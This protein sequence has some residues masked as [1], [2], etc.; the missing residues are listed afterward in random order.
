MFFISLAYFI[1][2]N[3]ISHSPYIYVLV[4]VNFSS[5]FLNTCPWQAQSNFK[6]LSVLKEPCLAIYSSSLSSIAEKLPSVIDFVRLIE[7][8]SPYY[9]SQDQITALF[10]KISNVIIKRCR[11]CISLT[12]IFEGDVDASVAVVMDAISCCEAWKTEYDKRKAA[13]IVNSSKPWVVNHSS[14]F[15]Q[16]DAFIQRCKDLL[17]VCSGQKHFARKLHAD[18]IP[19]PNFA[20]T[21]GQEIARALSGVEARFEESLR[22]LRQH[23]GHILDVKSSKYQSYFNAFKVAIKELE[24]MVQNAIATAFQ[25]VTSIENGVELIEMFGPLAQRDIIKRALDKC[26]TRVFKMFA[27]QLEDVKTYFNNLRHNPPLLP[28]MPP[29]SGASIWAQGLLTQINTAHDILFNAKYIQPGA[30][31][32]EILSQYTHLA[33]ALR[34][35]ISKAHSNW[36]ANIKSDLCSLLNN[37]L[38][39]R[40]ES[41][42]LLLL[43]FDQHLLL[44]FA[45]VKYWI[46][47]GMEIPS[48]AMEMHHKSE[49]LR[50]LRCFTMLVVRDYN[51][52]I[53]KLSVEEQ[54]LFRERIRF[55]DSKVQHGLTKLTW[56]S[57]GIKDYYVADC[58]MHAK[59]LREHVDKYMQTN[60]RIARLCAFAEKECMININGKRTYTVTEFYEAQQAQISVIR[61]RYFD[62][63]REII[64]NLQKTYEV[65]KGDGP[66]V[67]QYWRRFVQ[68]IEHK[69]EEALRANL[70]RSLSEL[71]RVIVGDG[72]SI[73]SPVFKVNVTLD[74]NQVHLQPSYS[75]L[76]EMTLSLYKDML[77]VLVGIEQFVP[78]LCKGSHG[79]TQPRQPAESQSTRPSQSS[80][81]TSRQSYRF[82]GSIRTSTRS[83]QVNAMTT[84]MPRQKDDIASQYNRNFSFYEAASNDHEIRKLYQALEQG[85]KDN[86]PNLHAYLNIWHESYHEFWQTDIERFLQRY[87]QMNPPLAQFDGD[88]ARYAEVA[89]NVQKEETFSAI[90]FIQ[91][92]CSLLKY[93]LLELCHLWQTKLT[94]L[95][96]QRA[97]ADLERLRHYLQT[98]AE[99]LVQKPEGLDA[100]IKAVD[101]LNAA[102][103]EAPKVQ[104][105]FIPLH[106]EFE[107]LEKYEVEMDDTVS[108]HLENLPVLW[109]KFKTAMDESENLLR[110]S[111]AKCKSD[112]LGDMDDLSKSVTDVR[113][114]FTNNGPF[115]STFTPDEALKAIED[116]RLRLERIR[117]SEESLKG[118][119]KVFGISHEPFKE[120]SDTYRDMDFLEQLWTVAKEWDTKYQQW[121][122]MQFTEIVTDSMEQQAVHFNKKFVKMS[123][124]VK[125]KDWEMVKAYRR[126]VEQFKR[127]MPLI[128]DLKNPALRER[129]WKELEEHVGTTFDHASTEFTLGMMIDLGF[130]NFTEEVSAISGAASKELSIEQSLNE[131]SEVWGSTSLEVAKYK[132]RGHYILKGTDDIYQLLEDHQVTLSTM[133]A[134]RFVKAFESDVDYWERTLSTVLEVVEMFL[135]VQRQ[136]MYLENIF[137]GED[138]RRQLPV[139]TNKFDLI[140]QDFLKI[141][142]QLHKDPNAQSATKAPGLLKTLN[143]MNEV[144]EQIQKSLDEYLE[145]KRQYFPRFYFVSNDDLLEILGQSKNPNAV[146]PHLLKCFDNIKSLE[147][148]TPPGR[149]VTQAV[150]MH[151][152]DGEYVPFKSPVPLEGPVEGW[153]LRV[154][155]EMRHT[156]KALLQECIIAHKKQKRDKWLR[157]WA[158]QLVL[159]VSQLTWT[160]QCVNAMSDSKSGSKKGLKALKKKW[161]SLL[162]RLTE[163]VRTVKSKTQRKKLVALITIEVHSRD[164]IDKLTKVPN[165]SHNAFEW[166]MQLRF[167]WEQILSN[168]DTLND[169]SGA[170]GGM[171]G[172]GT[173]LN[174]LGGPPTSTFGAGGLTLASAVVA[175]P[176]AS[177]AGV[178]TKPGTKTVTALA[179]AMGT[180]NA[181]LEHGDKSKGASGLGG[182]ASSASM[183]QNNAGKCIIRQTNTHFTYG[184]EYIGNSGRLVITPLTDRCYMTLTTALHLKRGGSPKGPAGT[185]KTETVKDLGKSLGNYVIVINCSDGMDFKSLGGMF[186]GLA[187]TGAWGCFDEFNRI[188]I[189]VL[190]VVAQQILSILQAQIPLSPDNPQRRFMFEGTEINLRWSCGIFITMNPGYAGRTELP[191]NLKS[192]FR[193]ISMMKPDTGLI[194]EIILFGQGFSNTRVLAKKADT[195][196]KLA[197][198]QLSKQD[199]YD[200][201]LRALVSTLLYAGVKR[202]SM[203]D[204]PH[205]E[206]LLIAMKDMNVAKMTGTDLPLLQG[207]MSDLFPGVETHEEDYGKF[208]EAIVNELQEHGYQATEWMV[209]KV[210][211]LY[212]TKNSR[213]AVMI[214]GQTGSGKSVAWKT[215][216]RAMSQCKKDDIA[217]F[218][219]VRDYPL[220]PK[221]LSLSE[222][223]GA[224]NIST[225]EWTDGILSSIMRTVCSDERSDLKWIVFD[226]PVDTL[227]I[228]SM[229]SVMDDNKILTLINGERISMPSQVSLLFEVEDLAVASPA[230]VSRCGMVYH[231]IKD[232]GW[233]VYIDSWLQREAHAHLR[234]ILR[235]LFDKFVSKMLAFIQTQCV[236]LVPTTALNRVQSL[237]RLLSVLL[238]PEN[239]INL[240]HNNSSGTAINATEQEAEYAALERQVGRWFLYALIW[241]VCATV[242]EQGRKLVDNCLREMEGQFPSQDTVYEYFVDARSQNWAHWESELHAAWRYSSDT[243]FHRIH[244]PTVDTVRYQYLLQTL[245]KAKY[246]TLI[247]G[248]VG[249]GK[250]SIMEKVMHLLDP[251]IFNFVVIN[252]SSKTSSNNVQQILE[253]QVEKRTKGVFVPV[254]GKQLLA[255]LDDLNMPAKDTFGS[256]PPLELLRQWMEY[257]FIYDREHQVVKYIRDM[258]IVAA[259]GPPGGGR[260]MISNRLKRRFNLINMTF[261]EDSQIKRIFGTMIN[262]KL[263]DFDE[264]CKPIGQM[265]TEATI[266]IYNYMSTRMLPT[267]TKIHYLFNLRDIS[268]VFQGMLRAHKD[269]HDTKEVLTRLWVHECFRVFCDRLVTDQDKFDF[270]KL[271]EEKLHEVFDV[272][273][274]TLCHNREIPVF[275][276]IMREG[277]EPVYEDVRDRSKLKQLLDEK[278]EDYNVSG[279]VPMDLVLF[280]D[281]INHI[282]RVLRVIRQQRGNL[283]LIGVGGSGRQS[284]ARLASF[285]LEYKTFQIEVTRQ[286]RINEF[287]EDLKSLYRQTGLENKPT[288][289]LF[290]DTQIVME[291]FLEDINNILSSGEVP[292]L[293]LPEELEEI[294]SEL[295]QDALKYNIND[296][297]ASLTKFLIERVRNNLHVVLCMS[298]VGEAFRNR[299]RMYPGLVNC[300]TIDYFE[301]WPQEALLAVA[302]RFMT[303][304]DLTAES[305]RANSASQSETSVLDSSSGERLRYSVLSTFA[306]IQ[307]SVLTTSQRMLEEVKR[308]N[309]VTPTNYLELVTGYRMLL[310]EKRK[311]LGDAANKLVNGLEKIDDTRQKVEVMSVELEETKRQVAEYQRECDEYLVVIVQQKRDADDQQKAVSARS[312][313]IV[314]ETQE[315]EKLAADAEADLKEALPALEAATNALNSLN[316]ND[317]SEIKAY[318]KPPDI[319]AMVMEAVMVLRKSKPE[320][321]EAKRQLADPNFIKQLI[322]FDKDNMSDKVLRKIRNYVTRPEFDPEE[323]GRV[324]NAAKSLCM[325]VRAMDV[326]GRIF[327]VVE[328]KRIALKKTQ[329]ALAAKQKSL[330][331]AQAKLK[332]VTE[333]VEE[334]QR[335]YETKLKQQ[336]ELA[337]KSRITAIKLDRAAKLVSG[338]AGERSRWEESV[339]NLRTSIGYL[340]GDCLLAA[341]FLSYLGPF[342][343]TYRDSMVSTWLEHMHTCEI[344]CDPNFNTAQFL[345]KPTD[346]RFWNIQGLPS[347]RFST[348]NGV[349]VTRG[350]RWPLMIDPQG[351]AIK[352]VK[353]MEREFG[354][355]VV[356]LQMPDYIRTLENAIQFGTPVLMQNV[357]EELDPSLAPILNKAFTKIGGRLILRLGDKEIEY[358]LDFRFYITTKMANPHYTPETSTKTT[359]VNFAVVEEGL[360][361][362]LLGIVVS[363]ERPELEEQKNELVT[364]IASGKKRLVEL[365]DR[366][367]HLLSTA[368]G[369]L[370]D[371]E[372]LVNTLNSS[373]VTSVEVAEQL[374]VAEQTEAEI[375]SARE[376]YRSCAERASILFFVMNEIA[377]IDPMYQF[378]LAAYISLFIKSISNS[379]KAHGVEQRIESINDFHTYAVYRYTCRGLFEKHKLL[380]AFHMNAKILERAKKVQMNE[381]NFFLRGGQVLDRDAQMPNP[382]PSWI[383][384]EAW[385]NLTEME[386]LLPKFTGLSTSFEQTLRDW[387]SWYISPEPE[388]TTLPGEWE[389]SCN[390]LQRMAI[391]RSLR[392]DRVSV[393]ATSFIVNNL[394]QRFVE[395]PPLDMRAVLAD[396]RPQTPLIFVL[397]V[398][399]D[400]TKQLMDLAARCKMKDRF[401]TLSLGQGQA[402]IADR[403]LREGTKHGHWVFLANCHL[404]LSWMPALSKFVEMLEVNKPHED[405]RLWLSSKPDPR[406]P[407]SILQAGIKMTTEPPKG[408]KAN[409]KRLYSTL[410][411]EQFERVGAA[412]KYKRL[413]FCLTFFHS[414]LLERRKFQML[415][416]N[417][418]YPFNDSDYEVSENL[419]GLFL[420]EY[421]DTPWEALKYLIAGINYGGHVTDDWDRRLLLTY[422]NELF[423]ENALHTE[424]FQ[425]SSSSLYYIPADGSL[426]AYKDYVAS[427]PNI[428]PPSTFGQNA[429]ADISSMIRDARVLLDTLVSLQPAV[430]AED[431]ASRET[432]VLDLARDMLER[433]PECIDYDATEKLLAVEPNPLNVVLLQ[434]IQRYNALLRV[435]KANFIDLRRGIQGLVVMSADLEEILTCLYNGHVPPMWKKTYPSQK[436]LAAWMRDLV[437]RIDFFRQW[438][439]TGRQPLIYWM[440]AFTFPT[441]FLTAVLQNAARANSVSIDTLS[442]EFPVMTLDDVNIVEQPR[443]G[444]YVKGLFLEGAGWDKKRAFL[445]DAAPMQLV[446]SM[447]T[448]HF[449]PVEKKVIKKNVYAAPCYYYPNRAGE[450]GASAW[451]FVI[452]VDL[453]SGEH[454]PEYWVKRGTAL[455][456][457]LDN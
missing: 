352:W 292:N 377:T 64:R 128:Q 37:P 50:A 131:I 181:S 109:N 144:L 58:R 294:F 393:V 18:K 228:E 198:Q 21:R 308:Y 73:P 225:N 120:I 300:T 413:M 108:M 350:R 154:E 276:D 286:Y 371:D 383:S 268:K 25:H 408:I 304:V 12:E 202:Q 344:P 122:N 185:G 101:C 28:N 420:D 35:Y 258:R 363:K 62:A 147:L 209:Q 269:F 434:E 373:K 197:V 343:S 7:L 27:E 19:L 112:L 451:S 366:I 429:N 446:C 299:L 224:F 76:S 440:S 248:P 349:I 203:P 145:T 165:I 48:T 240:L 234:P 137:T 333:H 114:D 337:E 436:P 332:E 295:R 345:A 255:F 218:E 172:G 130:D 330:A 400:P 396:S 270:I 84:A 191:D 309:Y 134:S 365:E 24:V 22:I 229:N 9:K 13:H 397:S 266:Q 277:L 382:A 334:L 161:V 414:I 339:S 285:V 54:G 146:Q 391:I 233:Q 231:D 124:E 180:V 367:L 411:E 72:K 150:G 92:D 430:S 449:K 69:F 194:A 404:S 250:T 132:E 174:S 178:G 10:Q 205:E 380:F 355:K 116:F 388:T 325:W 96:H 45:E 326:Y 43:N 432:I 401:F 47:L 166:L 78:I 426:Q 378:S 450:G 157:D 68:K 67:Q 149:K 211:Q 422:I 212:E 291:D 189:E 406:F 206:V 125:D 246:P 39:R 279:F 129:H 410:S 361:A 244:V 82:S 403:L 70:K 245:I 236:E 142:Q 190:S 425:V 323:V 83:S 111:K 271:I 163:A 431:G 314:I 455:L 443:D 17:V 247:A 156:L 226:G 186:S 395:P 117:G 188:N 86:E 49:E 402:P 71:V 159:T 173:A 261:P 387:Q 90:N 66:D 445:T 26:T 220:N 372:E 264:G 282:A 357:G 335:N 374:V 386:R 151:S 439:I 36:V 219:T 75:H 256:Q 222:L 221:A 348:E 375:D 89:N 307:H 99:L 14:V 135:L 215:L 331:D 126:R 438:A 407:I 119:L 297:S 158:G 405:F 274:S 442:W 441:G 38:L 176:N 33:A 398:G 42:T 356:D 385:D 217:D 336:H 260:T 201:G 376:G 31:G 140:D 267:P 87:A 192:M 421:Q 324:S 427:L 298:P 415:G 59:Q 162:N 392:P 263:Q 262:Q 216:Q 115:S 369:S 8:H 61:M 40:D 56:A 302:D 199:H 104:A 152:S 390:E 160:N 313:K 364:N 3:P 175:S 362:Q 170:A 182:D 317:I 81:S 2:A 288:T 340:V 121:K 74:H 384:S 448:I 322:N 424:N 169:G 346:V 187:Q 394:G 139:E 457:S 238:T 102:K 321:S 193:P 312:E 29:Y 281:A 223:Y 77:E 204:L 57:K 423:V 105:K 278:L 16:I 284:L 418:Q 251:S 85:M 252:M 208:R 283:L 51:Q 287:R 452:A 311:E 273:F 253:A 289:F 52:I 232:L 123:R 409:M 320:W 280:Q 88:I 257:G 30:F 347:D 303:D 60:Q 155:G 327:K 6:F 153:L 44:L 305:R 437:E 254:G 306:V 113:N 239:G 315:C 214:V 195:L 55:L 65:F 34:D 80:Q 319:V 370:L 230:T 41:R 399:V 93:G 329:D 435:M 63:H 207:M 1:A 360:E 168:A 358:N 141:G 318:T 290:V 167:Y 95:L 412:S 249:T 106:E 259:M 453:K 136:W 107:I 118:G 148:L 428:D 381:Y 20:G 328:P 4:I 184:Y 133:K 310:A 103:L 213:H 5:F 243:A 53:E 91:L 210:I 275:V 164:V 196:Y 354:L 127:T 179:G 235:K 138:I 353:N 32:D 171:S 100:V 98:Q 97:I 359:I 417:V 227:W 79:T 447:P 342:T 338:L 46:R 237:C 389:N 379:T 296:N 456:M 200:F 177:L 143:D 11:E 454:S 293:F 183:N 23:E 265:V 419:L 433:L 316:K 416:W 241:S 351:Q 15:A 94:E 368:K 444:V 272:S 242:N 301:P 110:E 341:G